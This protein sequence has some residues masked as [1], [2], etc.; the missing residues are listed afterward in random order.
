MN[1]QLWLSALT[2]AY[3]LSF[4]A[5]A[6]IK[7]ECITEFENGACLVKENDKYGIRKKGKYIVPT[8]FD[9]IIH[10]EGKFLVKQNGKT[11]LFNEKGNID[12][13]VVFTH[14]EVINGDESLYEVQTQGIKNIMVNKHTESISYTRQVDNTLLAL[15]HEVTI[16]EWLVYMEAIKNDT[17]KDML[18]KWTIPDTAKMEAKCLPAFRAFFNADKAACVQD[19]LYR[20]HPLMTVEL[21]CQFLK[22]KGYDK[23][24]GYPV[25]GITHEQAV[26]FCRW[27][28]KKLNAELMA[29]K[30]YS[31]IVRLPKPIEW[32][33]M[34]LAGLRAEM[35][36]NQVM[37]SLNI[38]KCQLF[39][40]KT[41]SEVCSNYAE[42]LKEVGEGISYD[43]SY[44]GDLNGLFHVFGNV[45]EM[46]NVKGDAKGGSSSHYAAQCAANVNLEYRDAEPWLGF[47][48]VI[49][50]VAK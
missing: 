48:Y 39:N 41:T 13:P 40:F 6:Q 35:R 29:E 28:T 8:Y 24:L 32:E 46:T 44:W 45:A 11:G 4:P 5:Q 15:D 33:N 2:L 50:F 19:F 22:M 47:R 27:L 10:H 43:Y 37:D 18:F 3:L 30:E 34:A 7:A 17:P 42:K 1:L 49:E 23:I 25:T 31:I 16:G 14:V 20:K 9:T 21:P 36:K 38:K 26:A 12:V